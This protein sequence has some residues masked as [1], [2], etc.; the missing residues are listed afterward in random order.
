[1]GKGPELPE[2]RKDPVTGRWVIIATDRARRPSDFIRH[3][4]VLKGG[5]CPFSPGN[6]AKTRPEVLAF[7]HGQGERDKPGW[8]V[9]VVPNKFPALGIEGNLDRRADGMYD[10]MNG[11]GAHEV[12]IETPNHA[13]TF[14]DMPEKSIEDVLWAFRDR[15][16]DL[17]QDRRFK[18][19]LIFKNHGEP[20][21]ATLEHPHSQ[22]IALPIVPRRVLDELEGAGQYYQLKER[23]IFC[24]IVHEESSEE[25]TRLVAENRGFVTVSPYAPR[26]PFE[27]CILPKNHEASF[28]NAGSGDFTNL[29][30]MIKLVIGKMDAVLERPAYNMVLHTAPLAAQ[31]HADYYHWHIE[32]IPKLTKVAGFEWGTGF[33]INPTSPEEAARYLRE[34]VVETPEL[35]GTR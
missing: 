24:D 6:E 9:R 29:A 22:L 5:F 28:E 30:Q 10:R 3:T 2:L 13:Q 15:I 11:I 34:A 17:K 33:Y 4:V 27:T 19:I 35:A 25:E 1:L 16:V 31:E 20:A 8:S 14:A 12:I 18:Y 26:F 7:R 23:C 32:L 21:G